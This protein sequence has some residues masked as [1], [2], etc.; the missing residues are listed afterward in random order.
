MLDE[1]DRR[2]IEAIENVGPVTS[3]VLASHSVGGQFESR[4]ELVERLDALAE[5]G[6][7]RRRTVVDVTGAEVTEYDAGVLDGTDGVEEQTE[8]RQSRDSS[9]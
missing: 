4:D 1:R 8:T 9:R 6:D 2:L 5:A 7:L 3:H